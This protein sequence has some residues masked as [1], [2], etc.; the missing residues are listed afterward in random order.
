MVQR[1]G[2]SKKR[3]LDNMNMKKAR[4]RQLIPEGVVNLPMS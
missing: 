2:A 3:D 4:Q 1:G